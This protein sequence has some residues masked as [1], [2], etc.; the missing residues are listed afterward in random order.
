MTDLERAREL[1]RLMRAYGSQL[2][3]LCY[4]CLRDADLAHDAAQEAFL[5]AWRALDT[6]RAGETERAWL[7]S[8]A[9]NTCRDMRRGAWLRRRAGCSLDDLPEPACEMEQRDGEPLRAVLS[10]PQKYREAV[11][12]HY[13]QGFSQEEI[14]RAL[15]V[16]PATVRSRLAR[17]RKKLEKALKGWYFDA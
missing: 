11:I 13:Y 10:L 6:L 8:I 4:V 1:E 9:V 16:P 12:L 7:F 17:A 15:S 2:V 14:A 3:R 5:K